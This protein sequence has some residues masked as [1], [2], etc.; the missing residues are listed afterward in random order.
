MT[1]SF[2]VQEY[3]DRYER[4]LGAVR[5]FLRTEW[6]PIGVG[7]VPQCYCEYDS[8]APGLA[9]MILNGLPA[10]H[11]EAQL[12]D[13]LARMNLDNDHERARLAQIVPALLDRVA[14]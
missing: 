14:R 4:A 8:Y 10:E 1:F 7:H 3:P 12:R 13:V 9:R 2:P 6:D 5:M 11:I